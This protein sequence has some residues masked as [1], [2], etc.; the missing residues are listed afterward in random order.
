MPGISAPQKNAPVIRITD[1]IQY[2][3]DNSV[4]GSKTTAERPFPYGT[5]TLR[6]GHMTFRDGHANRNRAGKCTAR[7]VSLDWADTIRTVF[8]AGSALVLLCGMVSAAVAGAYDSWSQSARVH[9]NTGFTGANISTEQYDF[10]LLVR[11]DSMD[12]DFSEAK[13]DGSDLRFAKA[14]ESTAL[15]FEIEMWD[16]TKK[17]AAVWVNVDTIAAQD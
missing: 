12:I 17:E 3:C 9:V 8:I 13:T 11:L 15:S 2:L 5:S 10:P 16:A 1:M 6:G 14:D 7:S 4:A